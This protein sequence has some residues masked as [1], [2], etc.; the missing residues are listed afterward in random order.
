M[1]LMPKAGTGLPELEFTAGCEPP[2]R[3]YEQNPGPLQE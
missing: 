3:C 2:R 1:C